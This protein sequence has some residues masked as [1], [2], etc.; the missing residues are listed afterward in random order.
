MTPYEEALFWSAVDSALYWRDFARW[1]RRLKDDA[2]AY[3]AVE[4]ARF[5]IRRAR[6]FKR[7][8]PCESTN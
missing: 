4:N 1:C 2:A 5:H 7:E 3:R 6:I 8:D